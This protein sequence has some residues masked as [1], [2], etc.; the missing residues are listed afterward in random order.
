MKTHNTTRAGLFAVAS[1][2]FWLAAAAVYLVESTTEVF[3]DGSNLDYLLFS[4]AILAAGVLGLLATMGVSKKHGE[5]GIKGRVGLV[6]IGLGV[7]A[8]IIAWAIPL[9][10]GLQGI[11][12]LVF[13]STVLS[14]G[15]APN[16]ATLLVSSG[17]LIGVV[18]WAVLTFAEAG[19]RDQYGDY[20][21][22]WEIGALVAIGL[23]SLGFIGWGVWLRSE[24]P[25]DV[26]ATAPVA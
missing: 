5:L 13:G 24:E 26:H 25:I 6:L 16:W 18:T 22:A 2:G 9:W 14:R 23:V 10:M 15:I 8:S 19:A 12:Y 4:I 21:L 20:P 7:V 17:F 1:A 3:D 11:G